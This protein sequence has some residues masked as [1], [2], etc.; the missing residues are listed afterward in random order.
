MT[1]I[2]DLSTL[3]ATATE[4]QSV[5]IG[6][7][8]KNV[9]DINDISDKTAQDSQTTAAA[10]ERLQQSSLHLERLISQFES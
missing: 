8:N 5:V 1:T 9:I 10:C 4:E 7:I 6:E 3:V 2:S